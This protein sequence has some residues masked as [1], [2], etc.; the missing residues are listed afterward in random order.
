MVIVTVTAELRGIW[1]YWKLQEELLK[2]LIINT[3]QVGTIGCLL[4]T[5]F[6]LLMAKTGIASAMRDEEGN[7]KKQRNLKTLLGVSLFI[8]YLFGLLFVGN[9]YFIEAAEKPPGFLL[10]WIN[11]FGIFFIVHLYDLIII[12]Y[13][14]IVR[15]HPEFLKL[16][17]TNYYRSFQPHVK[18]FVKG[19]PIGVVASFT[20]SMITMAIY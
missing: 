10:L 18:G 7:F 15:W 11:S 1:Y 2:N 14:I 13:F 12:D 20:S 17:D 16:P 19:I 3:I 8:L 5:A 4:F 9:L 6:I